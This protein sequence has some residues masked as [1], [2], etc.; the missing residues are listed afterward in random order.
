MRS[1]KQSRMFGRVSAAPPST[2]RS[3]SRPVVDAASGLV[4]GADLHPTFLVTRAGLVGV[5]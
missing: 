5:E 2:A 1:T 3:P 4:S